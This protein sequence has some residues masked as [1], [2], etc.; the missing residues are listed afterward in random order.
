MKTFTSPLTTAYAAPSAD[1][2]QATLIVRTDGQVFGWTD[3]DRNV[4]IAGVPYLATS[5]LEVTSAHSTDDLSVDTIDVTAFLDVSTE[6]E[7]VAG[8][9]DDAVLTMFEF[10][11]SNLPTALD[12]QVNLLRY[13]NL[14]QLRRQD[15][16]L[17]TEIRGLMQRLS[18]R[19]GRQYSPTC[20]WRLGD[21]QCTLDITS[22]THTGTVSAVDVTFP[23]MTFSDSTQAQA[24]NYFSEGELEFLTGDNAGQRRLVRIWQNQTFSVYLPLPYPVV[25]GDTYSAVKGDD[26]TK[27]TCQGFG[28]YLNFGGFADVPGQDALY[29]NPTGL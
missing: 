29:S 13:G 9:W 10:V 6:E 20:P 23:T 26:K 14:G 25:I 17:V 3:H 4:T 18:R 1:L 16:I 27:A 2:A 8:V 12:T 5:G 24:P 22:F 11:W 7:I 21:A 15:H 28:N 19:V